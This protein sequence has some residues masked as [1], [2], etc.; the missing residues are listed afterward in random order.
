M[1]H[2]WALESRRLSGQS[3]R[4]RSP[5]ESPL[6]SEEQT[7]FARRANH[8]VFDFELFQPPLQKYFCFSE[9]QI[10]LY[11]LPSHP[12]RGALRNVINAGR[13]AVDADG[14]VDESA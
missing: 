13:A 2:Q 3:G 6:L 10:K 8:C 11:G 14:A 5:H 4:N 12:E 7:S 9:M 1:S